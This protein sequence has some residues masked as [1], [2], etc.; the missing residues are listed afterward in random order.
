MDLKNKAISLI[1]T[2]SAKADTKSNLISKIEKQGVGAEV[3]A[4]L[5]DLIN[6][7]EQKLLAKAKKQAEEFQKNLEEIK[8]QTQKQEDQNRLD[9]IR[10]KIKES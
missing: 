3:L 1:S 2:L 9:K 8:K 5:A 4:E 6:K 7:A 10:N